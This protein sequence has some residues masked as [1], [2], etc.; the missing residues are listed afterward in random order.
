[1]DYDLSHDR[2]RFQGARGETLAGPDLGI[3]AVWDCSSPVCTAFSE[4]ETPASRSKFVPHTVTDSDELLRNLQ[5]SLTLHTII[6]G[7]VSRYV[8]LIPIRRLTHIYF[9][10]NRVHLT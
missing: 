10:A 3:S 1:M 6:P 4:R 7:Y 9:A 8:L 5:S 2:M